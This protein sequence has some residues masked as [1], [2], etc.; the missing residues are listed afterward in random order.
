MQMDERNKSELLA[1]IDQAL[2]E[3]RPH[4]AIDGGDIEVM[5]I[6]EEMIVSIKWLGNCENCTMSAL[7]MRAGVQETLKN[8][9]PQI[10][11]VIAIN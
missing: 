9:M 2:E 8:K 1:Q 4:L 10:K 7:T 6:S 11:S 3:L 5:D